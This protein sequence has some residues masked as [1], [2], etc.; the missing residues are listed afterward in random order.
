MLGACRLHSLCPD[1]SPL[2]GHSQAFSTRLSPYQPNSS[3]VGQPPGNL[4]LQCLQNEGSKLN[5]K[6]RDGDDEAWPRGAPLSPHTPLAPSSRLLSFLSR[7]LLQTI[8]HHFDLEAACR[9]PLHRLA[10]CADFVEDEYLDLAPHIIRDPSTLRLTIGSPTAVCSL[11][12]ALHWPSEQTSGT[13][14]EPG[15][16]MCC[17]HGKVKLPPL[18]PTPPFL[19]QLLTTNTPAAKHFRANIRV[20]NSIFQM[21]S[22]GKSW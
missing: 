21:P 12:N 9:E 19:Q 16:G 2:T 4:H 18:Q 7:M 17:N 6:R 3:Q 22:T 11:C 13:S 8:S 1:A 20:Y 10:R 14:A 5:L 15:F